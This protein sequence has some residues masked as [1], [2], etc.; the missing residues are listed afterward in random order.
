MS[1]RN[2]LANLCWLLFYAGIIA[3]IYLFA[4]SCSNADKPQVE[5]LVKPCLI[6]TTN[7][8]WYSR[9]TTVTEFTI[10]NAKELMEFAGLVNC[11]NSFYSKTVKLGANI[12]LNDTA[13][14]RNWK[15]K[16]PANEWEPIDS[17]GG[18]FYGKGY[19]ICGVYINGLDNKQGLFKTINGTIKNLGVVASYIKGKNFVG[20]LVG[21]NNGIISDSYFMGT[22]TG[23]NKVGGL[24]GGNGGKIVN[25]HFIGDVT[26]SGNVGGLMGGSAK[27][28]INSYSK[29]TITVYHDVSDEED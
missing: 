7:F 21:K 1:L 28:I 14:W 19:V 18:T 9:D 25:S 2:L 23:E 3:G 24:V 12:M 4:K 10:S 22:I 17:F 20:G 5:T 15:K 16:P 29:G 26:G 27:K 13:N 8:A 11:G 6:D